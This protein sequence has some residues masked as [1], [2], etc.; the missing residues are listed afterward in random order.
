[1]LWEAFG[2]K[3]S[4]P[5]NLNGL[6]VANWSRQS[7][8][9]EVAAPTK[10]FDGRPQLATPD[11]DRRFAIVSRLATQLA[12]ELSIGAE[13]P[14]EMLLDAHHASDRPQGLRARARSAVEHALD[15]G[16]APDGIEAA[17]GF[18]ARGFRVLCGRTCVGHDDGE[19]TRDRFGNPEPECL[20]RSGMNQDIGAGES[21]RESSSVSVESC[22]MNPGRR[23]LL[24]LGPFGSISKKDEHRLATR[25][26]TPKS[27]KHDIEAFLS[28]EA[29]AADDDGGAVLRFA[30]PPA[31]PIGATR[32]R[33]EGARIHTQRRMNHPSDPG[34]AQKSGLLTPGSKDGI[35]R[36]KQRANPAP[37]R[38]DGDARRAEAYASGQ[39][40]FDVH[41]DMIRVPEGRVQAGGATPA[42]EH[43]G[44]GEVERVG[45]EHVRL[46]GQ[47]TPPNLVDAVEQVIRAIVRKRRAGEAHQ[48]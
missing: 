48:A 35:E 45:F 17:I 7:T 47:N 24:E 32:V 4:L 30:E 11:G 21:R 15:G 43:P 3:R 18:A 38:L 9:S 42:S 16:G 22:E 40:R 5:L 25:A 46:L 33:V 28:R 14:P 19:P 20:V 31:P 8:Q 41:P 34:G 6:T 10:A 36:S 13:H 39:H 23:F 26:H 37:K 29:S 27:L 12:N 1:M 44:G 2:G